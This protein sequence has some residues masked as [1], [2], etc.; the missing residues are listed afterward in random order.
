MMHK[1]KLL[2]LILAL[3]QAKEEADESIPPGE[4]HPGRNRNLEENY[5]IFV[6]WAIGRFWEDLLPNQVLDL[7]HFFLQNRARL[8]FCIDEKENFSHLARQFDAFV[9][10]VQRD[11]EP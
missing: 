3:S 6:L 2:G 11:I 9:Q 1:Q 8:T 4:G 5:G 7:V 10:E